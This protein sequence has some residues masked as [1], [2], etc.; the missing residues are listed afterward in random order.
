ME[1]RLLGT[2]RE[3]HSGENVQVPAAE[4][5]SGQPPRAGDRELAGVCRVQVAA[6]EAVPGDSQAPAAVS[7]ASMPVRR[8]G[9]ITGAKSGAWLAGNLVERPGLLGRAI[10]FRVDAADHPE[11][12]RH[13][14]AGPKSL[15]LRFHPEHGSR[16]IHPA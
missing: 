15:L 12:R 9:W 11:H 8:V 10:Q 5:A 14:P 1:C 4:R 3:R 2:E 7:I 13:V 6:D 16:A